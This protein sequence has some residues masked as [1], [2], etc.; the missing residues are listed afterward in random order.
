MSLAQ[1]YSDNGF[2]SPVR[3]ISA[4]QAADHR[5]RLEAVESRFGD[6]HYKSKMHTLLDF[7]AG[8]AT[9]PS[10]LDVVEQLLGPDIML[11][12]V[13]YIIKEANSASH[14]SWH[15]DLT[16][17]G[18]SNDQQV[19]MWLALSA[20]TPVSGCMRMVP[21]SHKQ[22]RLDHVDKQDASNVLFRGQ[23]VDGVAEETAMMCPLEPGQASFHHGWT[24]H[25]SMPNESDDRR[26]GFNVQYINPSARQTL[27]D[28]DSATLVRGE[29]KYGHYQPDKFATGV[30]QATDIADH[31]RLEKLRK[32]TW[33]S[34]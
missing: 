26:I 10:V 5:A 27:H 6:Q 24:L 7:A 31:A 15:Q 32:E 16:Y 28:L 21:G 1:Q 34:A 14:V 30:M 18:L 8:L 3:C 12:D 2:V 25:A 20:A 19:S 9:T 33:A 23:S 17:W 11:F 13:T 29:D 22:G 4:Q